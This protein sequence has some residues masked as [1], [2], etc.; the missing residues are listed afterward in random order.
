MKI[1][2]NT[3]YYRLLF[4]LLRSSPLTYI[5][6]K[7]SCTFIFRNRKFNERIVYDNSQNNAQ[8]QD[9]EKNIVIS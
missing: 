7:V 5:S 6:I 3:R 9:S 8:F 4:F 2:T 1:S